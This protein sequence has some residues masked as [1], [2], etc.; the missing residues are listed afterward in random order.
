MAKKATTKT[1]PKKAPARRTRKRKPVDT[2]GNH[3]QQLESALKG[4]TGTRAGFLAA[5]AQ[6]GNLRHAAEL[7]GC[8]RT[9]H[10]KWLKNDPDYPQAFALAQEEAND[11]LLQEARRRA[12][13]GVTRIKKV[14]D[15][16]VTEHEYSDGLLIFL[17]KGAMPNQYRDAA[18]Y[19]N[20]RVQ[21]AGS[22]Q[23]E[24]Q[25]ALDELPA[26]LL[27]AILDHVRSKGQNALPAPAKPREVV[28][29][30]PS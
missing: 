13:E 6:T 3:N 20:G 17:I 18:L 27:Q 10:Y 30:R 1:A 25:I 14:G 28:D 23:H 5:F 16:Y 8:D 4:L 7:S 19:V 15:Q 2:P 24:H 21:H 9:S 26:P 29:E 12:V 11:R 22:V